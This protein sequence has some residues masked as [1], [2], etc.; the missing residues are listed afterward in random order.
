MMITKGLKTLRSLWHTKILKDIFSV[1]SARIITSGFYF[2]FIMILMSKLS[3]E[4]Y[5]KYTYYYSLLV[6]VPFFLDLGTSNAFIAIGSKKL[7]ENEFK[8]SLYKSNYLFIKYILLLIF[9]S[10]IGILFLLDIINL[11]IFLIVIFGVI[12]SIQELL[13]NLLAVR[14]NFK[15]M[16]FLMPIKNIVALVILLGSSYIINITDFNSI[17]IFGSAIV[18]STLLYSIYISEYSIKRRQISR[19][20]CGSFV[21]YSG[22]LVLYSFATTI[23]MR[24]EIFILEYYSQIDIINGNELGYFSAAFSFVFLLPLITNSIVRVILPNIAQIRYLDEMQTYVN[25]IKK[26]SVPLSVFVFIFIIIV[27]IVFSLFY[28]EKYE[29]SLLIFII[30]SISTLLSFF[31]NLLMTLFYTVKKTYLI[32]KVGTIQLIT[33]IILDVVLIYEFAAIGASISIF[34]VRVLGLVLV[35]YFLK[36]IKNNF[37]IRQTQ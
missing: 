2:I 28:K 25:N 13:S 21:K 35:I 14:K 23:M 5:G 33:N 11:N 15:L 1:T 4:E 8:F 32:A 7:K 37:I 22:W 16:S 17:L 3:V 19:F 9:L 20:I 26:I 18:F 29:D 34:T 30:I 6:I 10:S 27:T 31:T 24:L 36:K 12:L